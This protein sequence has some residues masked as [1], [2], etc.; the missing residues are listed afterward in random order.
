MTYNLID[1][2]NK[3]K[4][5]AVEADIM[6]DMDDWWY[7][8]DDT[9]SVQIKVYRKF[10][11]LVG[12]N[13]YYI[14]HEM[15]ASISSELSDL[16]NDL[17]ANGVLIGVVNTGNGNKVEI[18]KITDDSYHIIGIADGVKMNQIMIKKSN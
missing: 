7:V 16:Y 2:L 8:L 13:N 14:A 5:L 18:Y 9:D 17:V 15:D 12:S 6:A 11:K 4:S 10:I 1:K 3:F